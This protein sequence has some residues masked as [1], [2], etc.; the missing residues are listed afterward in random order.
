MNLMEYYLAPAD[1]D[2]LI[3]ILKVFSAQN[4][5]D[6]KML[7]TSRLERKRMSR[8]LLQSVHPFGIP[9]DNLRPK[10]RTLVGR[11]VNHKAKYDEL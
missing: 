7:R 1:L 8:E 4:D 6:K 10:T 9:Q 3:Q 2:E 5:Y 11:I